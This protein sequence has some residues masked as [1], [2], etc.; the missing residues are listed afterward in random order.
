MLLSTGFRAILALSARSW[1]GRRLYPERPRNH[2]SIYDG[3]DLSYAETVPTATTIWTTWKSGC[4]AAP[5]GRKADVTD[6]VFSMSG[7]VCLLPEITELARRYNAATMVDDA[8]GFGV[9][10]RGGRGTAD[11]F[12][13]TEQTDMIMGTF[14]KS[15]ASIG[16]FMAADQYVIDYSAPQF[17]AP[18]SS[19]RPSPRR[20]PRLRLPPCA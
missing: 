15:L 2:A 20:P 7:D 10:G 13:L 9:L 19:A 14:S 4:K 5:G 6:G 12:G 8:H 3:C 17:A 18:L 1:P 11:H 16:G